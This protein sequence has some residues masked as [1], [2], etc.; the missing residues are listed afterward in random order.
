[1][2][3]V[4]PRRATPRALTPS[5]PRPAPADAPCRA[6]AQSVCRHASRPNNSPA[7]NDWPDLLHRRQES[8]AKMPDA[9]H[10]CKWQRSRQ[11][12]VLPGQALRVRLRVQLQQGHPSH[13]AR[14]RRQIPAGE[15][16]IVLPCCCILL[17][18]KAGELRAQVFEFICLTWVELRGFEPRTSCMPSAGSTSTAVRLCRSPSQ[19]VRA[20]PVKSAPVAVLSCCTGQPARSGSQ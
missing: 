1:M 5:W 8:P 19:E 20:R 4:A 7:G 6:M 12:N 18:Y 9:P 10:K 13:S 3:Q 16:Y 17:L 2:R 15:K 11:K 14:R